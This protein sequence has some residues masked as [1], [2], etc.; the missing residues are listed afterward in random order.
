MKK[1]NFEWKEK[2]VGKA[3]QK[4]FL[5][6]EIIVWISENLG[7]SQEESKK[8]GQGLMASGYLANVNGQLLFNEKEY[9]Y[10][11]TTEEWN[12]FRKP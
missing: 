5:G 3:N 8:A 10:F 2:K 6:T 11:Q 4:C 12:K 9:Y 7:L 1:A